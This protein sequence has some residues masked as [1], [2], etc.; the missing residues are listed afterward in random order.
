MVRDGFAEWEKV[1]IGL[2]FRKVKARDE[3]EVRIGFQRGDGAWSYLGRDVLEYGPNERTINFGW[4]LRRDLDTAP[5]TLMS[6]YS[7]II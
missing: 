3:A 4:V 7:F 6:V 1:G 5:Y 2:Q